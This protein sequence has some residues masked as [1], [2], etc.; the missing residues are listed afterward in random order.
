MNWGQLAQ[1][2][3]SEISKCSLESSGVSRFPFT[4]EHSQAL[5]IIQ[6]WMEKAGLGAS[7][8]NAGTLIGH[9]KGGDGT[10][11][12][13]LGSHQDS[14]RDGGKYDGIMGIVLACLAVEKLHTEG[15]ETPFNIEVLAF[16][17]EEGVRFPT[18]LLGP[19]TLAGTYDPAVL[20]M[21]DNDGISLE[22]ALRDFGCDPEKLSNL[23]R[24]PDEIIGYLE[25]HIEQGPVLEIENLALGVVTG[26]CGIERNTVNFCGET[27]HA[28]TVPMG[29]RKD[30]LLA[31][32]EFIHVINHRATKSNEVLAT[33]GSISVYPN[34]VNAIPSKA[35]LTLEIRSI[36]DQAR[37]NFAADALN[38]AHEVAQKYSA[39]FSFLQT[40]NQAAVLCDPAL[41]SR[42]KKSTNNTAGKSITL[43]SGATHD[44]SAMADLCPIAMLFVRCEK[45]I[46][47]AP[48]EFASSADMH[49]AVETIADFMR[50]L[51]T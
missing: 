27:G 35:S 47:H 45:G 17:D 11:T 40:Y 42:L 43:P 1:D 19:R 12:L 18:A 4:P 29:N 15:F 33:V 50:S 26:I 3:L 16:A 34:V 44:A 23:I 24:N 49:V 41:I 30:A 51:A 31:A 6:D 2:R 46:S 5:A 32:S 38:I 13:F 48:E 37:E 21:K 25:V 20:S 8:D 36:N 39:D 22:D 7:L 9:K 28:G 14:V 10:K